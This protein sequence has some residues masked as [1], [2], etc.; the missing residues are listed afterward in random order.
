MGPL[1][2]LI[3]GRTSEPTINS[4]LVSNPESI[5]EVGITFEVM[6]WKRISDTKTWGYP[7][8]QEDCEKMVDLSSI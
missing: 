7:F 2:S 6:G 3:Y 8:L 5:F 1:I 4:S